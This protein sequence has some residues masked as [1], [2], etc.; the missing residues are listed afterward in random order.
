MSVRHSFYV[1]RLGVALTV[2]RAR[3]GSVGIRAGKEELMGCRRLGI[4]KGA[5]LS[6][7]RL[8][9]AQ[10]TEAATIETHVKTQY[11]VGGVEQLWKMVIAGVVTWKG[12]RGG[13]RPHRIRTSVQHPRPPGS[14]RAEPSIACTQLNGKIQWHI[15]RAIDSAL[16]ACQLAGNLTLR[17]CCLR[18][19]SEV[20]DAADDTFKSERKPRCLTVP[21]KSGR[22]CARDELRRGPGELTHPGLVGVTIGEREHVA[23][24]NATARRRFQVSES[25]KS[26]RSPFNSNASEKA[27]ESNVESELGV[28]RSSHGAHHPFRGQVAVAR[29]Y[30]LHHHHN[31]LARPGPKQTR[32]RKR[33]NG[34]YQW[35][36]SHV[37]R[38]QLA[39]FVILKL[40]LQ[41]PFSEHNSANSTIQRVGERLRVG[42]HGDSDQGPAHELS[43]GRVLFYNVHTLQIMRTRLPLY[44]LNARRSVSA[45]YTHPCYTQEHQLDMSANSPSLLA[46]TTYLADNKQHTFNRSHALGAGGDDGN[47][48]YRL[49]DA[50]D[51]KVGGWRT[52]KTARNGHRRRPE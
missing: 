17:E 49:A 52:R 8:I 14:A 21:R 42:P 45:A 15:L 33:N 44:F 18:P 51:V 19:D 25:I 13:R 1:A 22:S 12:V 29:R 36:S 28:R 39:S 4:E 38:L 37:D 30:Q 20:E 16:W 48:V 7:T 40:M 2:G 32:D 10:W 9:F 3:T 23:L 6:R 34:D 41:R 31:Q 5:D 50:A 43:A 24:N 47:A 27:Y 46:A 11:Q 26:A 35:A